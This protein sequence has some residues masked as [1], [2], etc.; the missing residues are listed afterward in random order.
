MRMGTTRNMVDQMVS[1][2]VDYNTPKYFSNK[3]DG[4]GTDRVDQLVEVSER[5]N[6]L[7]TDSFTRNI[8]NK[9]RKSQ[10]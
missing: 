3:E 1:E 8:S 9:A 6:K 5:T 10:E 2:T 4:E 7:L